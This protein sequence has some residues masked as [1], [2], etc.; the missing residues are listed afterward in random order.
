MIQSS[1]IIDI[2]GKYMIFQMP[3]PTTIMARSSSITNA[4]YNG[5]IPVIEPSEEEIEMTLSILEI[6]KNNVACC[7]CGDTATEWDHLRPIIKDKKPTGY[8]SEIAN[9]VPCCGKCNQSKGNKNWEE[10]IVS[11]AKKSPKS[12]GIKGLDKKIEKIKKYEKQTCP[13]KIEDFEAIVGKE[14]W[15]KHLENY[16]TIIELMKDCQKISNEIKEKLRLQH[17]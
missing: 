11:S 6:D 3:K 16:T 12:R 14:L 17:R 7:Y 5:I 2:K 8:I 1:R 4:F 10:W 13:I 9:L 15:S